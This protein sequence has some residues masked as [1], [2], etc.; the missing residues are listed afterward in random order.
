MSCCD[1][2][3]GLELAAEGGLRLVGWLEGPQV[4]GGGRLHV[5]GG[6]GLHVGGGGGLQEGGGGGLQVG[7]KG[8][9]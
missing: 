6:G 1:C 4:G 3:A 8:S 2:P 5:G 7:A 9:N